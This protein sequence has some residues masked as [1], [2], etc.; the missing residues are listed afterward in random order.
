MVT[1]KDGMEAMN[2]EIEILEEIDAE[3]FYKSISRQAIEVDG[4]QLVRLGFRDGT[5]MHIRNHAVPTETLAGEPFEDPS[6]ESQ[7]AD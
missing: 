7:E 1:F 6:E 5:V 4:Q 3:D 2:D